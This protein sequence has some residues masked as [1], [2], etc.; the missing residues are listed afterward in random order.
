MARIITPE[1]QALRTEAIQL[2][3]AGWSQP[4]ISKA[5]AVPQKTL[6][7]WLIVANFEANDTQPL[8]IMAKKPSIIISHNNRAPIT[9]FPCK[10]E[11]VGDG[12]APASVDL[13]LTDPPYQAS[14]NNLSRTLQKT[15][16]RRDYG[17]WDRIPARQYNR[18]VGV[19][20]S[21]MAQHLKEGGALYCFMALRQLSL[22]CDA[23]ERGGLT[24][25]NFI[26]WHRAN[27]APQMRQTKWCHAFD[28]ILYFTKSSPKT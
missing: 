8:S 22:W 28:S 6:S 4:E 23:F 17:R 13:I 11:E 3:K 24:Y 26:I 21:L 20:A 27:P 7:N 19:W 1:R 25:Q 18:S 12:I 10:Y 9:L 16:L 5:L 14:S 2:R 15:D